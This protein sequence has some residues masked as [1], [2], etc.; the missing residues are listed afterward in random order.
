MEQFT[1]TTQK[2][3]CEGVTISVSVRES[4]SIRDKIKNSEKQDSVLG[5]A[6]EIIGVI[7]L[8]KSTE[9]AP[10]IKKMTRDL[11]RLEIHLL[12]LLAGLAG[13][14]L[15]VELVQVLHTLLQQLGIGR[16][17]E[18]AGINTC[19]KNRQSW[20]REMILV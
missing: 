2:Q 6:D 12:L 13:V 10:V 1:R 8:Q 7:V 18:P 15:L 11:F 5:A 19:A 16:L 4:R 20:Q 17:A 3:P 9:S 14:E